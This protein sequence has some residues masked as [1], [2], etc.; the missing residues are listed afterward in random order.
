MAAREIVDRVWE[1]MESNDFDAFEQLADPD[2]VM[3]YGGMTL[4]GPAE[5]RAFVEQY[6]A[7]FP[8]L[9]HELV[10]Y[11][12]AGDTVALELLVRGTHT[13]PLQTPQGEIPATGR[14][15]VFESCDYVKVLD[16]KVASWHVYNDQLAFLVQL[17]LAADPA[18][19]PV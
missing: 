11:V 14:P 10:D 4:N 16:G 15:V 3:R 19:Q 5:L 2:V 18:A 12:E 7:A 13:G 9:H 1:A 8:D 6:K 17:G